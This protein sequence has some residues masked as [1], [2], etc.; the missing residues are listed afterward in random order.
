MAG[1]WM[2]YQIAWLLGALA[3]YLFLER[4]EV[5]SR[6]KW[7]AF[8]GVLVIDVGYYFAKAIINGEESIADLVELL[9]D[10]NFVNIAMGLLIIILVG[11]G[12]IRTK[13]KGVIWGVAIAVL[14][15]ALHVGIGRHE[16]GEV[17]FNGTLL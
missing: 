14:W 6:F 10:W 9:W 16:W 13:Y 3:V 4:M 17:F 15:A 1:S 11:S 8:F 7:G 2:I 12:L 5:E